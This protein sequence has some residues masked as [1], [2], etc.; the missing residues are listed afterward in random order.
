MTGSDLALLATGRAQF[1]GDLP[2]PPGSLH[3]QPATSPHAHARFTRVQT[4]AALAEPGVLAVLTAADVPGTNDVGNLVHDEPLLAEAEVRCVGEPFALVIAES[5]DAAWRAAR[6]VDADW[7]LLPAILDAREAAARGQLIEPPRIIA[8][9]AVD[10]AW[11][12]C[13]TVVEGSVRLGSADH[14]YLETQCAL[15]VPT[16]SGLVVHSSTQ[17]PSATQAAI[18]RVTGLPMSAVEVD[19]AR[20]GGGF[21]GKEDQATEWA[22][23][24]ALAAV[25][26][27]RPVRLW[28]DRSDDLRITGKRH[29]YT[30]DYRLGLDA[31]GHFLAYEATL[32]QDAGCLTDLSPAILERSLFHATNAYAIRHVRVTGISC[33]TNLPA[34][35]AFRGFGAPQGMFV[36]EAAIRTAARALGVPPEELQARNLLTDGD[37]LHY[38]QVVENARATQTWTELAARRDPAAVRTEIDA[39][40]ATGPRVRR[41][42]AMLPI[43]FGIAFTATLLNQAEALVHIYLDGTVGVTTGAVE[44]GQGVNGKIRTVVAR[45][46]GIGE[47]SVRIESTNT[48][49][50]ANVSPTAASTGADLNGLAAR[51]ACLAILANLPDGG[52][53]LDRVKTAYAQRRSLSALAHYATPNVAFDHATNQGTPFRYHVFGAALVEAE[54]DVL[55]GTGRIERVTLVHDCGVSLDELTDRGQIEGALVQGI[56]WMTTE[57]IRHDAD[58]RLLTDTLATYKVPDLPDAPEID[59]HLLGEPNPVGLL[60]SKA[61]GEP[62]LV[63]GLGAF[64]A[65]QDA[66]ASYAP[67]AAHVF[68]TP[69]TA[70]RIFGLL[71]GRPFADEPRH[72]QT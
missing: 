23:C 54:V 14:V 53:W 47:D 7:E 25:H 22:S 63:Y 3:A 71:H 24:A 12:D 61:V 26:T 69:L 5:P 57:E 28:L 40:N 31:A 51:E 72:G 45:T 35:T 29:P 9:G 1:T 41:G 6:L 52:V 60:N 17:S 30:A 68:T 55:L 18:A 49:R 67:A 39:W 44:M 10:A 37:V 27:G 13:T 50:V 32:Y 46:L 2:L 65:L 11:A 33:R 15:A 20:L 16:D 38:G 36:I 59:V 70:E 4:A 34:N 62:P 19:V 21:G 66:I 8:S 43:C 58:G 48:L 64:F 56:G 42:M